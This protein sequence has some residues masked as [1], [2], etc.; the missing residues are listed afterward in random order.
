MAETVHGCSGKGLV[1]RVQLPD[2]AHINAA[3]VVDFEVR[4]PQ[5]STTRFASEQLTTERDAVLSACFAVR[6]HG[7]ALQ[8]SQ[9]V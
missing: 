4:Q 3:Q 2:E 5:R 7:I 8:R 9:C 1:A 6:K